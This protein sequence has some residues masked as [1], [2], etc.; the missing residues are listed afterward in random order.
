MNELT[1]IDALNKMTFKGPKY[2][3]LNDNIINNIKVLKTL[4]L[5]KFTNLASVSLRDNNIVSDNQEI[6]KIIDEMKKSKVEIDIE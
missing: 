1:N 6:V 4:K 3:Y 2:L 5:K